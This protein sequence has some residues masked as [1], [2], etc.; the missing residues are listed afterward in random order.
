MVVPENATEDEDWEG[1]G[2]E[3]TVCGLV[4]VQSDLGQ[5][6]YRLTLWDSLLDNTLLT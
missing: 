6:E 3:G 4:S 1:G 2:G 5:Q